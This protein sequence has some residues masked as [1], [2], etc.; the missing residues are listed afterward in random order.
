VY[1]VVN[2]ILVIAGFVPL[3]LKI[4]VVDAI[5]FSIL[6]GL[7]N[8]YF[9]HFIEGCRHANTTNGVNP[10]ALCSRPTTSPSSTRHDNRIGTNR[11]IGVHHRWRH[12]TA[13]RNKKS[14]L[15]V[16]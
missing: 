13:L 10:V 14:V 6:A 4:G 5:S 16:L 3:G 11:F 8:D 1:R 9:I 15:E 2:L 12:S 7:S